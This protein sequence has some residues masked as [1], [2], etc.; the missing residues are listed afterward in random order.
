M[1][2]WFG[3]ALML[4]LFAEIT[5]L[6]TVY[7]RSDSFPSAPSNL[8]ELSPFAPFGLSLL[9]TSAGCTRTLR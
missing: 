9:R 2:R 4:L 6:L 7:V 3:Y 8:L 5:G 1:V